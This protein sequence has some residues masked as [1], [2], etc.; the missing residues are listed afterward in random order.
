MQGFFNSMG[1]LS[2]VKLRNLDSTPG[3]VPTLSTSRSKPAAAR[4]PVITPA[5]H[6]QINALR[7][8]CHAG[9]AGGFS[10]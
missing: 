8:V 4:P 1:N 2:G 10:I 6:A 9:T 7:S 5:R 3:E